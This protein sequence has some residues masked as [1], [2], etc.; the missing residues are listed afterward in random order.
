VLRFIVEMFY[1]EIKQL[2]I[3]KDLFGNINKVTYQNKMIDIFKFS[4][5]YE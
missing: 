3:T 5:K 2:T 4:I 1:P